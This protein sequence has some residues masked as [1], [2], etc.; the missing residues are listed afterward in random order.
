MDTD[1]TPAALDC[2]RTAFGDVSIVATTALRTRPGR[3]VGRLTLMTGAG[4]RSVIAKTA[5]AR[6]RTALELLTSA[7]VPGVPGLLAACDDPA[8]VLMEDAGAGPSVA[9]R[10][11]GGDPDEATAAVQRWAEAIG[12]V[13]A[14]TLRMGPAFRDRCAALA[15]AEQPGQPPDAYSGRLG[16]ER[17]VGWKVAVT[18]PASDEVIA[19]AFDG[20]R[21]GLAPLGVT[22]GPDVLTGLRAIADRLRADPATRHGPGALTPG[23]A[24]PDNNAETPDGLVLLDFETAGF[25]HIAW[26]A[27]YLTVPWPTCWCSWRM[28]EAVQEAALAR[29]RATVKPALGPAVTATLDGAI[30]DATVAWALITAAWFLRAAHRSQPLGPGGRLRPG[31]R[32]LVQHRLGVA[33]AADPDGVLGRVAASALPAIRA[34]WGDRPLRLSRAW[35]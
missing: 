21:D 25:R 32:E 29:W 22:A 31:S 20:L 17:A 24:C 7:N 27:A 5:R 30:R 11:L 23:D 2:A 8:L 14:A 3:S 13:Q 19:D 18:D 15:A 4:A 12:R 1:L 6:E 26:D 16:P 34:A 28:P 33:A 9:D 35:R 10:M